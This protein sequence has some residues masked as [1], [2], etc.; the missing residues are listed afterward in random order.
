MD[1]KIL[2]KNLYW[3]MNDENHCIG[4]YAKYD[5]FMEKTKDAA[6]KFDDILNYLF[7]TENMQIN[8]LFT[9]N[10][11]TI[12]KIF[13]EIPVY[14]TF[15]NKYISYFPIN[16]SYFIRINKKMIKRVD[17]KNNNI[18]PFIVNTTNNSK[19]EVYISKINLHK[20]CYKINKI[21]PVIVF[22]LPEYAQF[23]IYKLFYH[24]FRRLFQKTTCKTPEL[25]TTFKPIINANKRKKIICKNA[26]IS[27]EH[28]EKWIKGEV[29]Y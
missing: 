29:T 5:I 19:I 20:Y 13:D 22:N 24:A 15:S 6:K 1:F 14:D 2:D 21:V 3:T 27:E 25:Y 23:Q 10:G 4:D 7:H 12:N 28:Y 18:V 8:Y 17:L 26:N 11:S 9:E 16:N